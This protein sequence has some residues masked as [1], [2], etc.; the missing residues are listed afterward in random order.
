MLS[1]GETSRA[2]PFPPAEGF[3][4]PA[5]CYRARETSASHSPFLSTMRGSNKTTDPLAG[6]GTLPVTKSKMGGLYVHSLNPREKNVFQ[7]VCPLQ[8]L[9]MQLA[10]HV[11]AQPR[12]VAG[13]WGKTRDILRT[14]TAKHDHIY[15]M[16]T[17]TRRVVHQHA[18]TC[19]LS[20][21]Y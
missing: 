5:S 13:W 3:L 10:A 18:I 9:D 17:C 7:A 20:R 12:S 19:Q 14:T 21:T 8:A 16:C 1:K 11:T 6:C 2:A 4:T 15:T